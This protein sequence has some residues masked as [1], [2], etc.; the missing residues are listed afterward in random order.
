MEAFIIGMASEMERKKI[1]DEVLAEFADKNAQE[2]N[3]VQDLKLIKHIRKKY[4][5]PHISLYYY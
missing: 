2:R 3:R 5:I 1:R 4:A